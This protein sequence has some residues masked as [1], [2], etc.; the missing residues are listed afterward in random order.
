MLAMALFLECYSKNLSDSNRNAIEEKWIGRWQQHLGHP[1]CTPRQVM[2][3]YCE[4][5]NITPDS[6]DLAMEWDCWPVSD[7]T[8]DETTSD[9][10]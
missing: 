1:S 5:A 2:K 3:T 8:E 7:P 4:Y 9:I 6:L 10:T